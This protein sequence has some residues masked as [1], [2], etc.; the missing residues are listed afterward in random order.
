MR[1]AWAYFT[2]KWGARL[3]TSVPPPNDPLLTDMK[4]RHDP[5]EQVLQQAEVRDDD[6]GGVVSGTATTGG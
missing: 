2:W 5:R 4:A 3:I 1:W 6:T